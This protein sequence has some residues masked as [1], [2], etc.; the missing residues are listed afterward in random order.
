MATEE[1]DIQAVEAEHLLQV[2]K[3]VPI[4]L[5]RGKG[6]YV[7]DTEDRPYLD[8]LSGIGVASLGHAHPGL[9]AA[10]ADQARTLLHTSNLYYHPF[11][12]Q[13]GR[14]LAALSGLPRAFFC[15]SGAEAVEGC[16]KFA[17]RYWHT[18]GETARTRIVALERS[19]HG[20]TFGALSTTWEPRYRAPFE[21]LLEG[22]AFVS[23]T[24]P[25]A[26]DTAVGSDVA[27]IILEPIQGEGGVWPL[28]PEFVAAVTAACERTGT[29]L[30]ADEIQCGLGRTGAPFHSATVGLH[31]DL[32]ALGKALGAGVPI[33]AILM[34]QDVADAISP[35]DHGTTYGGNLLAC[36]AALVFLDAMEHGGLDRVRVAG[37]RLAA[38]L[39]ALAT[40]HPVITDVRGAGLMR[41]LEMTVEAATRV[42]D[43]ALAHRLLVNRAAGRVVRMLPPLTVSDEEIDEG[44]QILDAVLGE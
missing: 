4:V 12:G 32:M 9:A 22:V 16:L 18:R 24:D 17:R 36:R 28:S 29:L 23:P 37:T 34:S 19:F 1:Q 41:G 11:Q 35:G 7:Y 43:G 26:L 38:G 25:D 15:N 21:P 3:R 31:P 39:R 10:V 8:F 33:G 40:R 5:T 14:R 13:L 44:L 6:S 42:V 20:R 2:Y 30:I 27:A